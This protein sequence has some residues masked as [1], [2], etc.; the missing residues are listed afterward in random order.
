M[1]AP[2]FSPPGLE[3]VP[4]GPAGR[5]V[6]QL[7]PGDLLRAEPARLQRLPPYVHAAAG[8]AAAVDDG[9][10]AGPDRS[11]PRVDADESAEAHLHPHLLARLADGALLDGLIDLHEAAGER[12]SPV[13]GLDGA[14]HPQHAPP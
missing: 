1:A 2:V 8:D 7:V 5:L 13:A 14:A 4:Q 11:R 9:D 10:D 3:P 12:P 6:G